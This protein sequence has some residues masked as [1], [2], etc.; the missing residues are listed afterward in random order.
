MQ[1]SLPMQPI[2]PFHKTLPEVPY[3]QAVLPSLY[4][5]PQAHAHVLNFSDQYSYIYIQ[6]SSRLQYAAKKTP[7]AV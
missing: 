2:L 5:P 1:T 4:F 3:N 6:L 7:V